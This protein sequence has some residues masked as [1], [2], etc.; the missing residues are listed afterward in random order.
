MGGRAVVTDWCVGIWEGVSPRPS[1]LPLGE[2]D[3][4]KELIFP[5]D[6]AGA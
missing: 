2:L 4:S 1:A 3:R 5:V 6:K